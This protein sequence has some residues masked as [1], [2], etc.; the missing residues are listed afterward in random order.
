MELKLM[1]NALYGLRVLSAAN[2]EE[3][4]MGRSLGELS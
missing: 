4:W 1:I 3:T 2:R